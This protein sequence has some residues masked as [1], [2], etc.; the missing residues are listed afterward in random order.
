MATTLKTFP[1]VYHSGPYEE[2]EFPEA[3]SQS[4]KK[5][6]FVELNANSQVN[7]C[8]TDDVKTIGI[9]LRDASGVT[10]AMCPVLLANNETTFQVTYSATTDPTLAL[11]DLG[12][13]V[14]LIVADARS[15]VEFE[16]TTA[17]FFVTLAPVLGFDP[18]INVAGDDYVRGLVKVLPA[19]YQFGDGAESA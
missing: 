11:T 2:R 7:I 14:G 13:K 6:E 3:A 1:A 17:E 5:G 12:L 19:I 15:Y 16:E 18:A 4:F 10:A 9:A 8:A